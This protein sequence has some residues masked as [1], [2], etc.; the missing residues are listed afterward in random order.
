[1]PHDLRP[2]NDPETE[3]AKIA[4]WERYRV[5]RADEQ[6]KKVREWIATAHE[7]AEAI[8]NSLALKSLRDFRDAYIAHNL[9]LR[10]TPPDR[11]DEVRPV[12]YGDEMPILDATVEIVNALHLALNGSSFDWEGA[13]EIAAN[14]ASDLWNGCRFEIRDPMR[15]R[16]LTE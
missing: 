12:K 16:R 8:I 9:T 11:E 6:A 1:M 15:R 4:W 14:N 7:K 10:E 2:T 5:E 13:R 3:A